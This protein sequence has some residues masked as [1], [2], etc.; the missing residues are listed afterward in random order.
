[1]PKPLKKYEEYSREE[2]HDIFDPFTK[3]TPQTG[4]WGLRGIVKIPNRENDY[5]FFV[6]Y[7]QSQAGHTFD[8]KITQ[9]GILTWQSQPKQK[10]TNPLIKKLINHD[11]LKNNIY[12]FL[13]T[14]KRKKYTYL[15]RLAYVSHD[16]ER[17]QPVYFKWQILDWDLSDKQARDIG[18]ELQPDDVNSQTVNTINLVKT[19]APSS[20]EVEGSISLNDFHA[21]HINFSENDTRN[22]ELGKAGELQVLEYERQYLIDSGRQDLAE[23]VFHTSY[24]EGDGA[25]YDILSYTAEGELKYIEVKTTSGGKGTPFILTLNELAFSQQHSKNYYL[26]RVYEFNKETGKGKFYVLKGSVS[27]NFNLEPIQFKAKR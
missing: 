2:V 18:L 20:T 7:G 25:G 26:Y 27:E 12:L 10:L 19:E 22:K 6:T 9:S 14:Q 3:F 8:E 1:M 23:K 13:R 11:H 21:R 17:E 5:V 15:G 4:S 24:I 16:S